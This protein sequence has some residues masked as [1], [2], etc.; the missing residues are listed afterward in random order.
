MLF[1]GSATVV[2][3]IASNEVERV[4]NPQ[5]DRASVAERQS[6]IAVAVQLRRAEYRRGVGRGLI[7]LPEAS[8]SARRPRSSSRRHRPKSSACSRSG[9]FLRRRSAT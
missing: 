9:T 3:G 6:E 8:V 4:E 7:G 1:E 5:G 2:T